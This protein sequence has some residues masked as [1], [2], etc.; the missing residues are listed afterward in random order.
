MSTQETAS[1]TAGPATPAAT[2]ITVVENGPLQVKGA[3]ELVDHDGNPYVTRRTVFLCRCGQ[4]ATKPFCDGS[5]V[6]T[7]FTA[8]ERAGAP[9]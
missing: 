7:R 3:V 8:P 1:E 2:R 6:R 9:D 5:H 4:S